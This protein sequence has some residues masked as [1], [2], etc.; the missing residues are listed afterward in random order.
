MILIDEKTE[1]D[2]TETASARQWTDKN[3][4]TMFSRA[5]NFEVKLARKLLTDWSEAP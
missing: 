1:I 4:R 3:C 2:S 5:R